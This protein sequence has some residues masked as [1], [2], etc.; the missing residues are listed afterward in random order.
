MVVVVAC[1]ATVAVV[2]LLRT[3]LLRAPAPFYLAAGLFGLAGAVDVAALAAVPLPAF[4][5][6]VLKHGS[7]AFVLFAV[8]MYAGALP[9]ASWL[10]R[11]LM[12]VRGR[13]SIVASLIA[14]G[15]AVGYLLVFAAGV[16]LR[17]VPLGARSLLSFLLAFALLALL[18]PLAVTSVVAIR[19]RMTAARWKRLQKWAYLFF[20]LLYVHVA[21]MLVPAALCG[22]DAFVRFA[23]YT[24]VSVPYLVLFFVQNKLGVSGSSA[25][26]N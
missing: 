13:L 26:A 23:C 17:S 8:V 5:L 6:Y 7:V 14:G 11:Y 2:L 20:A 4:V 12:P 1:V 3:P 15:H 19:D 24:T 16:L 21:V 25:A 10:R 9:E 22:G 18:V